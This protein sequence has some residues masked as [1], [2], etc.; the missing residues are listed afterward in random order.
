MKKINQNILANISLELSPLSEDNEGLLRGG[1]AGLGGTLIEEPENPYTNCGCVNG[2]KC[3]NDPCTNLSCINNTSKCFNGDC[4]NVTT[5]T[6]TTTTTTVEY[7]SI[8]DMSFLI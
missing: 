6:T 1:F 4:T 3:K 5:T 7:V 8:G 2:K